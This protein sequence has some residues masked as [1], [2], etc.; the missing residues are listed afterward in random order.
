MSTLPGRD[1]ISSSAP[2]LDGKGGT[3]SAAKVGKST[4]RTGPNYGMPYDLSR[5]STAGFNG[6]L[7]MQ[8]ITVCTPNSVHLNQITP[9]TVTIVSL[10]AFRRNLL[11]LLIRWRLS[12][13]PYANLRTFQSPRRR[14]SSYHS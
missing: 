9:S 13:G 6:N 10:A 7:F 11:P 3:D 1:H 5:N 14:L 4:K 2:S 12:S 8:Y